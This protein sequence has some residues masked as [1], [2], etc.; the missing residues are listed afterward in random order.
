MERGGVHFG[1]MGKAMIL[2]FNEAGKEGGRF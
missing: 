1:K 2:L